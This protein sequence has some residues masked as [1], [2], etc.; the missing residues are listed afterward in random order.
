MSVKETER[1]ITSV[2]KHMRD[3]LIKCSKLLDSKN[4]DYGVDNFIQAAVIASILTGQR[5]EAPD[6]AACLIGIKMSRYG[7]LVGA[8]KAP[9]NESVDDT[10]LDL[11]NYILL[12]ERER[13]RYE[14]REGERDQEKFIEEQEERNSSELR[15]S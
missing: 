4:N 15:V 8:G 11:V 1:F 12:M 6:V 3:A 9:E 14:V 7:V 2:N 13:I 10:V 5:V